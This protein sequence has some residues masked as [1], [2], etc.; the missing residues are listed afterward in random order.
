MS[1]QRRT[2]FNKLLGKVPSYQGVKCNIYLVFHGVF[3]RNFHRQ[4]FDS[5]YV[6]QR[7]QGKVIEEA[8]DRT[9]CR[10]RFGRAAVRQTTEWM[11]D[12]YI[13]KKILWDH[14]LTVYSS[15]KFQN[16]FRANLMHCICTAP[17]CNADRSTELPWIISNNHKSNLCENHHSVANKAPCTFTI[18]CWIYLHNQKILWMFACLFIL[19]DIGPNMA[20]INIKIFFGITQA[21]YYPH[22]GFWC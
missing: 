21:Q 19:L 17:R 20:N 14:N 12:Y 22:Y 10:T 13:P 4:P 1:V 16:F 5:S 2:S 11:N 3:R 9:V 18:K 6:L 15:D 8:L 7:G